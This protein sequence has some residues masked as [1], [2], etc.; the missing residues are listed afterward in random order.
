RARLLGSFGDYLKERHALPR[1]LCLALGAL[2]VLY[3]D[4]NRSVSDSDLSLRPKDEPR[5]I[6]LLETI[7][8][9]HAVPNEEGDFAPLVRASLS[10]PLL[11]GEDL[12]QL[13]PNLV[14]R[15]ADEVADIVAGNIRQRLEAFA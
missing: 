2:L 14:G 12:T 8:R 6:E 13:H 9:Y 15:V 4:R 7:A 11:W 3:R 10:E 5:I 1:R